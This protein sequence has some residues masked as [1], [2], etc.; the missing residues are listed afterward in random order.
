MFMSSRAIIRPQPSRTKKLRLSCPRGH[1]ALGT[2][3]LG[4]CDSQTKKTY[5][6]GKSGKKF[7]D[8]NSSS[9]RNT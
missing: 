9:W 5:S 2:L 6:L 3:F 4:E 1:R 7:I 8:S